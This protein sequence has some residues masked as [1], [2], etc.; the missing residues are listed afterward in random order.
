[1]TVEILK[2]EY[3]KNLKRLQTISDYEQE[4]QRARTEYSRIV[5][6]ILDK[7]TYCFRSG[8]FEEVMFLNFL[9]S[10]VNNCYIK[11]NQLKNKFFTF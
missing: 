1:M 5:D 7:K 11:I 6:K 9:T 10:R 3:D 2:K 8:S 4:I